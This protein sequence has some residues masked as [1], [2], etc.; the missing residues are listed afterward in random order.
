MIDA[1]GRRWQS[2]AGGALS[3]PAV[4]GVRDATTLIPDG[5]MLAIDGATGEVTV[6]AE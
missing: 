6:E 5:A 2:G 3:H 4:A 1:R